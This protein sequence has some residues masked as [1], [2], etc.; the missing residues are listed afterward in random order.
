MLGLAVGLQYLMTSWLPALSQ[1]GTSKHGWNAVGVSISMLS[2]P[3]CTTSL[4]LRH[5]S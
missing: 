3:L 4:S 2:E 5:A 1:H